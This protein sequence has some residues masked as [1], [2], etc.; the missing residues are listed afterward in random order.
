MYL[1]SHLLI[2]ILSQDKEENQMKF[3]L[4]CKNHYSMKEF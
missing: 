2:K 1:F 4:S 3:F